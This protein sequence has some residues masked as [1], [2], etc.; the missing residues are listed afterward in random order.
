MLKNWPRRKRRILYILAICG[1]LIIIVSA[2]VIF[3]PTPKP[4]IPGEKM[5][6]LTETLSRALP[7][8]YPRVKFIN[9]S[10]EAGIKFRHFH[11]KRSTQ[12]PEDMGSG[13]AW[14]DYDRDGWIDLY[15]VNE[16]GPLTMS[17][18]E[19]KKSP[20]HNVLY[21]NQ[22]DG[23]FK[24]VTARAGV[25]YRGCGQAAAWGDY[26]ND[27]FLDL[28]VTNYGR[29]IL[30]RNRG[31]GTFEEASESAGIGIQKG[32]WAGASWGDYNR[33]G[34]LDLYICGYV[35]YR[36]DPTDKRTET[37]QD[38]S[39]MPASLNPSTYEPERNLLYC[40][41]GD[42]TFREVALVAGVDNIA[43][44]SLSASWC[45]FDDDGWIDLYVANDI[46]DN[47]M[48]LNK[49]DGTFKDISQKAW[50]ADYRGAMG[51]A[52]ADWD[53]DEDM[54]LFVTHW[55]AQENALYNNGHGNLK[56]TGMPGDANIQFTDM[57]DNMGLGQI[58]LD[59]IGWGTA[60]LDYNNDRQPDLFVVNGSTFQQY[61]DPTLLIPMRML[62]F[63]NKSKKEGFF[64][65]GSVSGEVFQQRFVG[66]GLAIGDYDNDGDPDAFVV[67]NGG[68]AMLLRNDGGNDNHWLK[69]RLAG[70]SSNRYGLGTKL[71]AFINGR[72][73]IREVGA[74]SS[75][76]SQNAVGEEL[77]GLSN[78]NRVDSLTIT[79]PSG[80]MQLLTDVA[81]NQTILIIEGQD[82][83]IDADRGEKL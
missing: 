68:V 48:Y 61:E 75:Y 13:A 24:D 32:F 65:V 41:N 44:R 83:G 36:Y 5:E 79:W 63:W 30:Y 64:E 59:Y 34:N 31:D 21:R 47:V 6:G 71:K 50:V 37:R 76:Y 56:N 22:G 10:A 45:D 8:E 33:D 26:N 42:G 62:L 60:F 1:F 2:L 39:Y 18:E 72:A 3:R 12:L 54:D 25:G 81:T 46:S 57:A 51:L 66:R 53:G 43:G 14:G 52:V 11:G 80:K 58:A 19:I 38:N 9:V 40:N 74:G 7:E 20:A 15:V 28:I 78:N 4:Y 23:S 69:V 77:F 35:K 27:G 70:R 67:V 82:K 16:A 49:G 17:S 55:I 29:N 73:Q